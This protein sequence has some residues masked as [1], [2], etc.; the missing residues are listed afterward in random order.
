MA[1]KKDTTREECMKIFSGRLSSLID[2][3]GLTR[4][5]VGDDLGIT[6]QAVSSYCSGVSVPDIA[7]IS[8][9]ANYFGVS[10]DY[11][12]GLSDVK[13]AKTEV[14]AISEYTGLSAGS[15]EAL[16]TMKNG[17]EK[18][19]SPNQKGIDFINMALETSHTSEEE[20]IKQR[21]NNAPGLFEELEKQGLSYPKTAACSIFET[22]YKLI[23][24]IEKPFKTYDDSFI[25]YSNDFEDVEEWEGGFSYSL[26]K[27]E[28]VLYEAER[29]IQAFIDDLREKYNPDCFDE[30]GDFTGFCTLERL[31]N[32]PVESGE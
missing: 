12:M 29:Q 21:L 17:T 16:H 13:T 7:T 3:K 11:L 30:N 28:I 6:P 14:R 32:D 26:P 23:R 31:G 10:S 2:D 18:V 15:V 8:R 20:Y 1:R 9:I 19:F 25:E 24:P 27:S 4:R 5:I 22:L